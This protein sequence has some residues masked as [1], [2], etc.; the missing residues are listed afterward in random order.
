MEMHVPGDY[1]EL[2]EENL[3]RRRAKQKRQGEDTKA[4]DDAITRRKGTD[5]VGHEFS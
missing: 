3:E 4:A 1:A 2:E 5:S